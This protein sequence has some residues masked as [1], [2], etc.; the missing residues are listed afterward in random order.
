VA[1]LG[2]EGSLDDDPVGG[3]SS[4]IH[5][6]HRWRVWHG[7]SPFS[8]PGRGERCFVHALKSA[9]GSSFP[10]PEERVENKG[11]LRGFVMG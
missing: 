11:I 2:A 5:G 8:V 6:F 7:H 1:P 10:N 4:E 3:W 9:F